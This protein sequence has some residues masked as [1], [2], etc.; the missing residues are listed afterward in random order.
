MKYW[1]NETLS[2]EPATR[3]LYIRNFTK[4]AQWL[5]KTPDQILKQR[6]K[7]L[8]STNPKIQRTI[9]SYLIKF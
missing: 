5:N 8:R 4:F 7:N 9:E 3:K 6:Q 2:K 1:L